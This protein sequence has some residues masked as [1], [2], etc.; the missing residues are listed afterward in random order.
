MSEPEFY[1]FSKW[2]EF[3]KFIN[4]KNSGSDNWGVAYGRAIHSY[5]CRP[6]AQAGI[7]SY[8]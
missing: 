8:H 7:R 6:Y 3:Y 1:E 4:S 5:A 2:T